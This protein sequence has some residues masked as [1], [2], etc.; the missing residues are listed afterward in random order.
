MIAIDL[1]TQS[2]P[3]LYRLS[4]RSGLLGIDIDAK[5]WPQVVERIAVRHDTGLYRGGLM[6][7]AYRA[8]TRAVT[9]N[10]FGYGAT[11]TLAPFT[12]G[13]RPLV[14]IDV[15]YHNWFNGRENEHDE[16]IVH[17]IGY[18]L[19][20]VFEALA[21]FVVS[22]SPSEPRQM[23]LVT[24]MHLDRVRGMAGYTL[25]TLGSPTV[26]KL[27]RNLQQDEREFAK[28][29]V[30]NAMGEAHTALTG[31]T[32]PGNGPDA[33]FGLRL[34]NS[35]GR[36]AFDLGG[37]KGHSALPNAETAGLTFLGNNEDDAYQLFMSLAA[38]AALDEAFHRIASR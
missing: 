17:A 33:A 22:G 37:S 35:D 18:S 27:T 36:I 16:V 23:F 38:F 14:R 34:D 8:P 24:H 2:P 10:T 11:L 25:H 19:S 1:L 13:G 5:L 29:H 7:P 12:N 32:R 20:E 21:S 3:C 15:G 9:R 6:L 31:R 4:W 28:R 26:R 30:I